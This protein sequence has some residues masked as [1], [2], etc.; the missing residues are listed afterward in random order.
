MRGRC[1]HHLLQNPAMPPGYLVDTLY[2]T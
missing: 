2:P 1:S